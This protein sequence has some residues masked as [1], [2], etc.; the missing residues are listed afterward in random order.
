MRLALVALL[1]FG[2]AES[3]PHPM[4]AND[5]AG[6][7]PGPALVAY[8][9]QPDASATICNAN[10]RGPHVTTLDGDVRKTLINGLTDGTI[11]P[12]AWLACTNEIV[13]SAPPEAASSLLDDIGRAYRGLIKDSKLE[14][15][16]TLQARLGAM[17]KLY[18][19][20]KNGTFGKTNI[21]EPMFADLKRALDAHRLGPVATRFGTELLAA[22]NLEHG[23]W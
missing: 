22:V 5:I 9:A 6:H 18:L 10:A 1:T 21:L 8:L 11:A 14:T 19:D 17:Q 13:R 4:T 16:P 12:D 23:Q 7:D 2:C 3:L 15:S 20:R